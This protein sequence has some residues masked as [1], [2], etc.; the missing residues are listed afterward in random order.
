[1]GLYPANSL[2]LDGY[3]NAKGSDIHRIYTM[4]K[5]AG[6]D[7][8]SDK[9]IEAILKDYTSEN[10]DTTSHTDSVILKQESDL[11]PAFKL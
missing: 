9:E 11:R 3:L 8:E 7:I 5:D 4:I 6:F 2:F 1:M 10:N